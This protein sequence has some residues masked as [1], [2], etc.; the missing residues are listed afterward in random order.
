MVLPIGEQGGFGV[1]LKIKV[2]S[3]LT[4]LVHLEEV[5]WPELEK[6]LAELKCHDDAGGYPTQLDTGRRKVNSFKAT[7]V[8]DRTEPTHD[9]IQAAFDSTVPVDM[10]IQDPMGV[11]T[12]EFEAHIAKMGRTSDQEDAFKCEVEIQPTGAPVITVDESV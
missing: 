3:V 12:I 2:N 1:Q 8:W 7:L 11:E 4:A 10:S 6:T 5:D 9:A